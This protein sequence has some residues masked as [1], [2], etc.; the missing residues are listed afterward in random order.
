MLEGYDPAILAALSGG[1]ALA[2]RGASDQAI[3]A[4]AARLLRMAGAGARPAQRLARYGDDSLVRFPAILLAVDD[5]ASTS[6]GLLTL[7]T[8][9]SKDYRDGIEPIRTDRRDSEGGG[10]LIDRARQLLGRKVLVWKVMQEMTGE[11]KGREVRICLHLSDLGAPEPEWLQEAQAAWGKPLGT[12]PQGSPGSARPANPAPKGNGHAQRPAPA[13]G[14]PAQAGETP[15]RSSAPP[16][17]AP[18]G[19]PWTPDDEERLERWRAGAQAAGAA[20]GSSAPPPPA[21]STPPAP[22]PAAP[23]A[24]GDIY[25]P[26]R[27]PEVQIRAGKLLAGGLAPDAQPNEGYLRNIAIFLGRLSEADG[28]DFTDATGHAYVD[29]LCRLWWGYSILV[30][31][32]DHDRTEHLCYRAI[33]TALHAQQIVKHLQDLR[34][35]Q[36]QARM[37]ERAS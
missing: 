20:A 30:E 19:Y 1:A 32:H 34:A 16:D 26:A 3:E 36:Q 29:Q 11:Q 24:S 37:R 2:G 4:Q 14:R 10:P 5:E 9:P 7:Y 21:A 8:H 12:P 27:P 31:G 6:R 13:S 35:Y 28:S 22:T 25:L 33:R 15:A 17:P 18:P 23:P